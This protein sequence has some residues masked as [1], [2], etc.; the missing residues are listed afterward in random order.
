MPQKE[1]LNSIK[2]LKRDAGLAVFLFQF[3]VVAPRPLAQSPLA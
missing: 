1:A 3:G 2:S